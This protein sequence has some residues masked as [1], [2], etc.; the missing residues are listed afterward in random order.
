VILRGGSEAFGTNKLL[1][2]AVRGALEYA[3]LPSDCV[4]MVADTSRETAAELMA[5][6]EYIDVLIP[7]GGKGLINYVVHNST[8]PVIQ[9]GDG[10]CHVYVD[11]ICDPE[12]AQKIAV[13]A[14][15]S[16]PSV[17]NAAETL[18]VDEA[19]AEQFLPGC[20][21]ELHG[22]S[23]EIR[24]CAAAK[25]IC[26]WIKEATKQDFHTEHL[27]L[28]YNVKVV[29]G[30]DAAIEHINAH[31]TRHSEAIVTSDAE[32][33][34][35]FQALVD[36]SAVY[37]NASTRFTDGNVFGLGAEIGISNQKLHA[38]GPMGLKEMTTYKYE[39]IGDGHIR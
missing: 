22:Y 37:V 15:I 23:V 21:T 29:A 34:R 20:L 27:D 33:G 25:R 11:G 5:L 24:G 7:R 28:I 1:T 6:N 31:G 17:C 26:P 30:L 19:I 3:G 38:R 9:T 35:K 10:I 12:M 39:I 32:R 36:A 18:L 13:S 4:S 16:R 8:I 14:K 2:E